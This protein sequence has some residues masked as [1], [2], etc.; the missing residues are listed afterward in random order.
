M[1]NNRVF[2]VMSK[3][4]DKTAYDFK[5]Y[6]NL[7][8]F[9][10]YF[11]QLREALSLPISNLLEIGVGDGVFRDYIKSNTAIDYKSMDIAEDLNPDIIGSVKNIPLPDN[12][13]ELVV[14]YEVLEH[15]PF[16]DF[17]KALYEIARVSKKYAVISLP[18]FG[19]PIKFALKLPFLKE[20]K[21]A[22][23]IPYPREHKFNGQHYWEIGKKGYSASKI[24]KIICRH[25]DIKKEFVPWENQYHHF[26]V[27]EK[28]SPK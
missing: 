11:Y 24:R 2:E 3:Q 15:L 6:A 23:K 13:N 9:D 16:E 19:P 20:I 1:Q 4:V 10:S 26:Y 5:K 25:F 18:H 8:R 14:A 17:E 21:F 27:L 7:E 28:L 12:S 22:F